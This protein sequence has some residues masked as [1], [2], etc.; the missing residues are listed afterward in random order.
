[1]GRYRGTET[2]VVLDNTL[3][4]RALGNVSTFGDNSREYAMHASSSPALRSERA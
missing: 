1:M 3:I 2:R 4:G